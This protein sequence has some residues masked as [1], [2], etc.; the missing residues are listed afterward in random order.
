MEKQKQGRHLEW[1][2]KV[3]FLC[4]LIKPLLPDGRN[5]CHFAKISFLN[6]EGIIEKISFESRVYESVDD[7]NLS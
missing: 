7:M 2:N 1:E 3:I 6:K 4:D 5:I